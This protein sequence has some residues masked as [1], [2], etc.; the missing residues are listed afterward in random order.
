LFQISIGYLRSQALQLLFM[1][2]VVLD[3]FFFQ[4]VDL[5]LFLGEV[6]IASLDLLAP[7]EPLVP[8]L[9]F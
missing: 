4:I 9:V 7:F 6:I 8:P 1:L 3:D 5:F 2:L